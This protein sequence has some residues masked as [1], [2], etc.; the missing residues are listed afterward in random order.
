M[1]ISTGFCTGQTLVPGEDEEAFHTLCKSPENSSVISGGFTTARPAGGVV[2]AEKQWESV[3]GVKAKER[4]TEVHLHFSTKTTTKSVR[5][6]VNVVRS[7]RGTPGLNCETHWFLQQRELLQD[8][9]GFG[10]FVT[11]P[12][13][14]AVLKRRI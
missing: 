6:L 12:Q 13:Q 11:T 3:T 7:S 5:L 10:L 4:K 2:S 14:S 1:R 9:N 8:A